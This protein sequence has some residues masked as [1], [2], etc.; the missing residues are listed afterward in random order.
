MQINSY[1]IFDDLANKLILEAKKQMPSD[2]MFLK[3]YQERPNAAYIGRLFGLHPQTV[4]KKLKSLG[5]TIRQSP[6]KKFEGGEIGLPEFQ[7]SPRVKSGEGAPLSDL[8]V[9][10]EELLNLYKQHKNVSAVARAINRP[11]PTVYRRIKKV[12]GRTKRVPQ[13]LP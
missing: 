8:G 13:R 12:E 11:Q 2:E 5:V 6:P 7:P 3:A 4:I 1:M 10:D 9:S